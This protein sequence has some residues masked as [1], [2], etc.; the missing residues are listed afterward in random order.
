MC[1]TDGM[2]TRDSWKVHL[3]C[4]TCGTVGEAD[5]SEDDLPHA[6]QTGRLTVDRVSHGFRTRT[7][8][9]TMR[10]TKFECI[11]CGAVTQR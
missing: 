6:P 10:T 7:L 1:H 3:S 4:P 2:T 9:Y 5:V 11:L 8:G